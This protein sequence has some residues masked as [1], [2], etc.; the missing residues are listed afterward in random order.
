[1]SELTPNLGL[2]KYST[3]LDGK[4]VFSIDTA[5]NDNWDI[6]DEKVGSGLPIFYNFFSPHKIQ[7]DSFVSAYD[8]SWLDGTVYTTGY[9]ELVSQ[10]ADQVLEDDADDDN[11]T[12]ALTETIGS[13]T[14]TYYQTDKDYRIVLADQADNVSTIWTATAPRSSANYFILDTENTRFKLPRFTDLQGR[15]S[16]TGDYGSIVDSGLPNITGTFTTNASG[17][18]YAANLSGSFYLNNTGSGGFQTSQSPNSSTGAVVQLDASLSN[19]IY[20]NSDT[21]QPQSNLGYLYFYIGNF[22]QTATE[23]TAGI[24]SEL[25][26]GKVDTDLANI[27]ENNVAQSFKD[28]SIGWGMP[29]YSAVMDLGA[30]TEYTAPSS[31]IIRAYTQNYDSAFNMAVNGVNMVSLQAVSG[32]SGRTGWLIIDEGEVYTTNIASSSRFFPLKG[33]V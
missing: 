16:Y 4:Q 14:I 29:D 25:F 20:G 33:V 31:G 8:F 7:D 9:D 28:M 5:L 1:M 15:G 6:L 11:P 21:V 30:I 12:T 32:T 18:D 3:D 24:N 23:Q 2:F 17:T 19:S 13:T 22:S 27:T 10:M 26:N